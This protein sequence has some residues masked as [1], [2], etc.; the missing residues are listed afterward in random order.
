MVVAMHKRRSRNRAQSAQAMLE[1]GLLAPLLF[2][3][4]LGAVDLGRVFYVAVSLNSAAEQ[5]GFEASLVQTG[6]A[7]VMKTAYCESSSFSSFTW[8][9]TPPGSP[10]TTGSWT[11]V[12]YPT[13]YTPPPASPP[14]N[15]AYIYIAE[16]RNYPGDVPG[17]APAPTW[18][19]ATT[20]LGGR[21]PVMVRIDYYWQPITPLIR[22]LLPNQVVHIQSTYQQAEQY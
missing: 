6:D 17:P 5:A 1:M 11:A 12:S 8:N 20:R 2:M 9:F 21:L 13:G 16:D 18:N 14:V 7:N 15:N 19:T 22:Y 10:C 4:V 3:L